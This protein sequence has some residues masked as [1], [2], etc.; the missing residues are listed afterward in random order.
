MTGGSFSTWSEVPTKV[1]FPPS[2]R[3]G[4]IGVLSSLIITSQRDGLE[5]LLETSLNFETDEWLM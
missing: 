5:V 4:E 1:R 2:R 3:K